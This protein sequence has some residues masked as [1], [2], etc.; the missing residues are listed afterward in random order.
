VDVVLLDVPYC[1]GEEVIRA[2][3][4]GAKV[5]ALDYE[6]DEAPD[7]VVS[8]QDGRRMPIQTRRHVGVEF[9]IIRSELRAAK[10]AVSKS[11]DVLVLVGGGN[12]EGLS[13]EIASRLHEVSLCVVQGP[14]AETLQP[15]RKNIRVLQ[16]PSR[17]PELMSGCRWAVTSGG[18]TMLEML[19]FGKAIHVVPRTA[20]ET[21]F[22]QG[23]LRKGAL[24]GMGLEKLREPAED[25]IFSCERRGPELIDGCGAQ[26]IAQIVEG[27]L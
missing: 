16:N 3:A 24:L 14:N 27:F 22:A 26:R 23:F 15:E 10:G 19:Y 12:S 20:A 1:G 7:V 17:L 9:A 8:L 2:R 6:G 13:N 18:T 25:Q 11:G 21:K 4:L 5:I